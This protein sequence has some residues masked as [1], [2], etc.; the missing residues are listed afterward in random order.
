M[1]YLVQQ[2]LLPPDE[3]PR[4]HGE[5]LT[6]IF[7]ESSV[8][9]RFPSIEKCFTPLKSCH[10]QQILVSDYALKVDLSTKSA[11]VFRSIDKLLV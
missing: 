5:H 1:Y 7:C 10:Q 2:L 9:K 11:V 4:H 3:I 6:C 8:R